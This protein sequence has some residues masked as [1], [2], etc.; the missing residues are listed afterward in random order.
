M[1]PGDIHVA[2]CRPCLTGPRVCVCVCV[3]VCCGLAVQ[4][5]ESRASELQR[6]NEQLTQ[7]LVRLIPHRAH[8]GVHV[9]I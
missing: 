7:Q 8:V 6:L 4:A 1:V 5:A 9:R 3:C 2:L